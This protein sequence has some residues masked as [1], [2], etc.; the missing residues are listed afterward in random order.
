MSQKRASFSRRKIR[1]FTFWHFLVSLKAFGHFWGASGGAWSALEETWGPFW[2]H[3]RDLLGVSEV[4]RMASGQLF[5]VP[6]NLLGA[7]G[8]VQEP[9]WGSL[10]CFQGP[11]GGRGLV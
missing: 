4:P 7:L 9:L 10:L 2:S 8:R 6:G 5:G 3:F 11:L 1:G